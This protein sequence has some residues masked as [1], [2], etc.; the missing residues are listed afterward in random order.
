MSAFGN[1]FLFFFLDTSDAAVEPP[2]VLAALGAA[3]SSFLPG[4]VGPGLVRRAREGATAGVTEAL[5]A[6]TALQ[7][8]AAV[9]AAGLGGTECRVGP[10]GARA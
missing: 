5:P 7:P 4:R 10:D 3:C 2:G 1:K 8:Q 6:A 9:A